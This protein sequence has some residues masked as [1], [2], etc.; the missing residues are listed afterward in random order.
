MILI[1]EDCSVGPAARS[2]GVSA[3]HFRP[4]AFPLALCILHMHSIFPFPLPCRCFYSMGVKMRPVGRIATVVSASLPRRLRS[5]S[6]EFFLQRR[7]KQ[8]SLGQ[9]AQFHG[10]YTK[11]RVGRDQSIVFAIIRKTLTACRRRNP[12]AEAAAPGSSQAHHGQSALEHDA[13]PGRARHLERLPS[14]ANVHARL[15]QS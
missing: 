14:T 15:F 8:N 5:D 4:S 10:S 12:G 2:A 3:F 13:I 11:L 1:I 6:D 9:F 7:R